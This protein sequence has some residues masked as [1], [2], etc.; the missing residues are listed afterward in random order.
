MWVRN[1]RIGKWVKLPD[2]DYRADP[3]RFQHYWA[4]GY[5]HWEINYDY[6]ED[7]DYWVAEGYNLVRRWPNV[8]KIKTA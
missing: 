4:T 1:R 5:P 6:K 2:D 7:R 8:S 3:L